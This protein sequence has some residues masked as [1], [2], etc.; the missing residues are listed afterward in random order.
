MRKYVSVYKCTLKAFKTVK[1]EEKLEMMTRLMIF[2]CSAI[3][4]SRI[5]ITA[6]QVRARGV[7]Y[8]IHCNVMRTMHKHST[9]V[10]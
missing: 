2:F 1:R 10:Y 5:A 8:N 7:Q 3:I 9:F 6:M 4:L